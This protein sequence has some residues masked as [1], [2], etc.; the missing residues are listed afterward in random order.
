LYLEVSTGCL[1]KLIKNPKSNPK[2][3]KIRNPKSEME[4][5]EIEIRY[6]R[7]GMTGREHST[8]QL[9]HVSAGGFVF[10]FYWVGFTLRPLEIHSALF[11]ST[12][13]VLNPANLNEI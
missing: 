2:K 7:N 3:S 5:I 12:M 13:G 9:S 1:A 11:V 8:A 10:L 6:R 4:G